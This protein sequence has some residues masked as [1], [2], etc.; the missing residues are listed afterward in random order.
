MRTKK[1]PKV[2]KTMVQTVCPRY[3]GKM[4]TRS[5]TE[6][7]SMKDCPQRN[8]C[9]ALLM[10]YSL[11]IFTFVQLICSRLVI[12]VVPVHLLRIKERLAKLI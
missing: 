2:K 3:C 6:S 7:H 8:A 5:S 11:F 1:M 10:L 12:L 4:N 9:H